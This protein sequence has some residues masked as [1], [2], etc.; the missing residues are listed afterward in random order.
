MPSSKGFAARGYKRPQAAALGSAL[1][2]YDPS[3]TLLRQ[4]SAR[5]VELENEKSEREDEAARRVPPPIDMVQAT[6]RMALDAMMAWGSIVRPADPPESR[7]R[8]PVP[9]R[10]D[11]AAPYGEPAPVHAPASV[12][13]PAAEAMASVPFW[14]RRRIERP[15]V[16]KSRWY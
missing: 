2:T 1:V 3:G 4:Q 9:R 7:H 8:P 15:P 11:W 6:A 12:A 13:A 10:D 14:R 5:I 16:Q